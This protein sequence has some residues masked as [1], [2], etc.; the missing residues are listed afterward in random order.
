MHTDILT[1]FVACGFQT[2]YVTSAQLCWG[3]WFQVAAP[4][5]LPAGFQVQ[6]YDMEGFKL[7]YVNGDMITLFKVRL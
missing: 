4:D 7:G 6:V 3:H 1:Q 5:I 2:G